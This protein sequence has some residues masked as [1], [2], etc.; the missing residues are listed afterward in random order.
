MT[1]QQSFFMKSVC[2]GLV[3][4][5]LSGCGESDLVE[6]HDQQLEDARAMAA[7]E[8]DAG[9]ANPDAAGQDTDQSVDQ[10]SSTTDGGDANTSEGSTTQESESLVT[11]GTIDLGRYELIFTDEFRGTSIDDTKWNTA[12]AWGADF[13]IYNQQQYY[14]DVQNNPD[15]GFNPFSLDG[16]VLTISAIQ[17]PDELRAAANEQSWLSGVLASNDKFEFQY[18]YIEA[19]VDVEEGRGIWPSF[20]MLSSEFIGLKPELFIMEYDGSKPDSVFHN[21][22]YHDEDDNLRLSG[23]WEVM[24][25]DFSEGFHTVGVE[26]SP[27]ELLFYIDRQPRYRVLGENIPAQDLYVILNLAMGGVWPGDP[28]GTTPNPATMKI[29]Y[30]RAYQLI[31]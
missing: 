2:A 26:W 28:D 30:V 15:F 25:E 11:N 9:A 16:E 23:Q 10:G 4:L 5:A 29:D 31:Q 27:G 6:L 20:W 24:V 7:A 19:R 14:V 18:G 17:T 22:N 21:Y 12:L 1:N 3:S 13:V 8:P